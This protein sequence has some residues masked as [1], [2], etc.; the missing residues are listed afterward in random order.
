M[1]QL[2]TKLTAP[3]MYLPMY[4]TLWLQLAL[5]FLYI[6]I[7]AGVATYVQASL[8]I[9]VGNRLT[10]RLRARYLASVLRQ[11]VAYFDTQTTTGWCM[12]MS[13]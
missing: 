5:Y 1:S 6:A 4:G 12:L 13:V 3:G 11:E 9:I 7:V 10:N 2:S 8:T